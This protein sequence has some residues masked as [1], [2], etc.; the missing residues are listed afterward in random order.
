MDEDNKKDNERESKKKPRY[1]RYSKGCNDIS[2]YD[3]LHQVEEVGHISTADALGSPIINEFANYNLNSFQEGT[4]TSTRKNQYV[5]GIVTIEWMPTLGSMKN[6]INMSANELPVLNDDVFNMKNNITRGNSRNISASGQEMA[7]YF[8]GVAQAAQFI[9]YCMKIVQSCNTVINCKNKYGQNKLARVFVETASV[10]D[11]IMKEKSDFVSQINK[12]VEKFNSYTYLPQHL[13]VMERRI[14][15]T[16]GCYR[17]SGV[18]QGQLYIFKPLAFGVLQTADN[19]IDYRHVEYIFSGLNTIYGFGNMIMANLEDSMFAS[20]LVGQL[21]TTMGVNNNFTLPYLDEKATLYINDSS[22]V[23]LQILNLTTPIEGFD[24]VKD[25]NGY[26]TDFCVYTDD[27]GWIRQGNYTATDPMGK[28]HP[29]LK[30]PSGSEKKPPVQPYI[31]FNFYHNNVNAKDWMIASRLTAYWD[32]RIGEDGNQYQYPV[33]YG[34]E[35]VIQMNIWGLEVDSPQTLNAEPLYTYY[36]L[37][38]AENAS[39]TS[40]QGVA[41]H[42]FM[43]NLALLE[44]MDWKPKTMV[45]FHKPGSTSIVNSNYL[46]FWET[47][48]LTSIPLSNLYKLHTAAIASEWFIDNSAYADVVTTK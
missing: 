3:K 28:Y 32:M 35:L 46:T 36:D 27:N 41:L 43:Y 39:Y 30:A 12:W 14:F 34:S 13:S 22:E 47:Q 29:S 40:A 18:D 16:G 5:P 6:Y 33:I 1:D 7:L 44:S 17:D 26:C 10:Y 48:N 45:R 37:Y 42:R 2:W 19:R 38:I 9:E 21:R 15:M 31:T 24:I 11:A 20:E 25:G 23:L 8:E 4:T